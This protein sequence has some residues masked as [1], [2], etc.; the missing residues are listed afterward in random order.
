[1]AKTNVP[2]KPIFTAEGAK[3]QH[4]NPELQLHRSVCACLLWEDAF[5]EDGESIADRIKN[6]IP[7]VA[8][9]KVAKLAIDARES[10]KLRHVPLLIIREMA[11]LPKYKTLVAETLARVIQRPDELSEFLSLYWLDGKCPLSAQV[12]KGLA[13]AFQKFNEYSLGKYDRD[14]AIKLRDVLFLCHAK[15]KDAEQESLWKRLINKELAVPDTWEVEISRNKSNKESWERLLREKKLGILATLRN[16]RNMESANVDSSL[17]SSY[18]ENVP[19]ERAL[20]FRFITAAQYAKKL[21]EPLEKAM[22]RCLGNQEKLPG[23]TILI[24]DVSGSM[25]GGMLSKKSELS[26][27]HAACALAILIREISE[28]PVIYA[29]AGSDAR[30]IHATELV[31]ARRGFS[32]SDYIYGQSG[33]LGGG[34]IFLKQ[35]IDYVYQ[36]ERNADRI[37]VITDEQ[38]CDI[39][40]TPASANAFGKQNYLINVS[41]EKNGIGYGKWVHIDGFS[42]ACIDFIK[43][44]ERISLNNI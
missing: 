4:I 8:P 40:G 17:I 18:L 21:E 5:Y 10:F 12:K 22:L 42:E 26:R 3:A 25:Y 39:S 27:A 31:P 43:E 9:E 2:A 38:D 20:P 6:L 15:P 32:L 13:T 11:R 41:V 44:Y 29:T 19:V 7:L 36:K 23:K 33:P 24:V 14:G 28:E 1:M 37:I 16:L 35:V 30:R 34:G